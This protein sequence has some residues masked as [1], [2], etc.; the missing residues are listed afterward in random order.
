MVGAGSGILILSLIILIMFTAICFLVTNKGQSYTLAIDDQIGDRENPNLHSPQIQGTLV[1]GSNY[2]L[3][4]LANTG[5]IET[6][7][8]QL[9]PIRFNLGSRHDSVAETG[10]DVKEQILV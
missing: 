8:S 4:Y 6:S 10:N 3:S 2:L 7:D 1:Y 5:T 9:E